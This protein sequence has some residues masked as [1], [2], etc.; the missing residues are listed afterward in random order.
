MTTDLALITEGGADIVAM[1]K[2][3]GAQIDP[4][5]ARIEAE[6]RSHAPDLTTDKGRKAIASLAYKV[7]QSKTALDNAGKKLTE[8][9]K[10]AI[11]A[12]DA[13][14]KKIRDRLDLLRDEAR[15]PLTD[16]EAAEDARAERIKE[17]LSNLRNHG[18]SGME[19]PDTIRS[20]AEIIKAI[21]IGADFGA[22]FDLATSTKEASLAG[23]RT[24]YAAALQRKADA[25]ELAE[26]RAAAEARDEADRARVEADRVAADAARVA[27][28]Q[29]ERDEAERVAAS[30]AAVERAAQIERDRLAAVEAAK[31]EAEA[32][33]RS[34][35]DAVKAAA[36]H[37]AQTER[38]RISAE[39]AAT[40]RATQIEADK[41]A[42]VEAAKLAA[43]QAAAKQRA[44]DAARHLR[45]LA[46]AKAATEAAA[47]AERD[48]IAA[49]AK[50]EAD[51]RAKR[52]ADAT[53]RAS[54]ARD[55]ADA[56]R[57]MSGKSTPELIAEALIEGRIPHCKVSM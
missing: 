53:H 39:K 28:E 30:Q 52:E 7:S 5:L 24:M 19:T 49:Q 20:A 16:W 55:I 48:R 47:Q 45:E 31:V 21:V 29:A 22:A 41:L 13:A 25:A 10:Q 18:I 4:I 1:F 57:T 38:D 51:A 11:A 9:Q 54:I 46:E 33:H 32:R 27:K 6:V 44:D 14:R 50:A 42:A 26:L 12:V 37:A 3:G 34:E 40:A 15:K 2:D 23:L 56:L 8:D 17:T 35:L 43:E 36:E